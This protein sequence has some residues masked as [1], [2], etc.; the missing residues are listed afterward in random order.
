MNIIYKAS[1]LFLAVTLFTAC[2]DKAKESEPAKEETSAAPQSD[3]V[4]ITA[5]QFKSAAIEL[6][7]IESKALS[8]TTKVNGILDVPPQNLVSISTPFGGFVKSTSLLQG[9]KV[10]KGQLV[11]MMQN[12]D[13]IQPQQDYIDLKS[14]LNYLKQDYDRQVQLS[15]ENINALKT[16]QKSKAEYESV[17]A[18]V[19]GLRSKL[20]LMNV[21]IGSLEA[22]NIQNAIPLYSPINGYVTQVNTNIGAFVN[23]EDV[24]FKIADTGNLHA[25]LTVFEKDVPKLQIGQKVRFTLANESKERTATVALIGR[26]ISAERTVQIHCKLDKEDRTLLPG[27]YLKALVESGSSQVPSVVSKAIVEFEG[28]K[29][30]FIEDDKTKDAKN[31][32]GT[33]FKMVNVKTGVSELNFTELIFD[34]GT[35]YQSWKVVTNGAYDLLSKMKNSGEEE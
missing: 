16:L 21:N 15:K 29:Y 14:Q 25:E 22:G 9:M 17:R 5:Q 4:E 18:R 10:S 26:E 12:P 11:A 35:E 19:A 30:L 34:E 33:H 31:D 32:G 1:M 13:Y 6:G 24:L 2:G 28:S 7:S 8:G 27:M 23:A 20:Q 3:I